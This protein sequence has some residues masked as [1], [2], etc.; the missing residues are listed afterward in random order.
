M[1]GL[2]TNAVMNGTDGKLWVNDELAASVQSFTLKQSNIYEDVHKAN[3]LGKSRRLLGY[4]LSG[5]ITKLSVDNSFHRIMEKYKDGGTPDIKLIGLIENKNTGEMRRAVIKGVTFDEME[6]FNFEQK[7]VLTE[8][9]PFEA[10][11]YYWQD[12]T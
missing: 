12:L 7:K 6:L 9:L 8:E 2:N 3:V 10:E 1:T 4:E 5:T 11:D